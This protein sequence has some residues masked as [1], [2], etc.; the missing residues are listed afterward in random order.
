MINCRDDGLDIEGNLSFT[1]SLTCDKTVLLESDIKKLNNIENGIG[2][3]N[4][5]LILDFNKTISNI[6]LLKCKSIKSS[7]FSLFN[8]VTIKNV[9][10]YEKTIYIKG[11]NKNYS[12]I[13]NDD[14]D[15]LNLDNYNEIEKSNI[16]IN[17]NNSINLNSTSDI[18]LNTVDSEIKLT[19]NVILLILKVI[20]HLIKLM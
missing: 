19:N 13:Y 6:A 20:Q 9:Q 16:N 14:K 1:T 11:D 12:M 5:A 17:S 18:I 10:I 7:G 8:R 15:N 2:K 3:P 4:K